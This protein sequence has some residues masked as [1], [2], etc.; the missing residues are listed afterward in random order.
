MKLHAARAV[1]PALPW[2]GPTASAAER[3][4]LD[5]VGEGFGRPRSPAV[6]AAPA[7]S[8]RGRGSPYAA[9]PGP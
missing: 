6:T 2:A 8:R 7:G 1:G 9:A 3:E 5:L 4:A